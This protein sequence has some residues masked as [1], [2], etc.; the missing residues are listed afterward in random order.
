MFTCFLPLIGTSQQIV[1]PGAVTFIGSEGAA[2][3]EVQGVFALQV[4][5]I[6]QD[7]S[8]NWV[9]VGSGFFVPSERGTN[10]IVLGVTCKHV[11]EAAERLANSPGFE[12]GLLIGMNTQEGY[13]R[14]PCNIVYQDPTNDVAIIAP[15][16]ELNA[17]LNI[18]NLMIP[19]NN[20]DD[21]SSLVLG[22][23]VLIIG[24]PLMLGVEGDQNHPI[25]RF[26][27]IAQ[28]S[29]GNVFLIDGM[30]SHG[31]SGS[32]VFALTPDKQPLIGMITS[33]Q[34]DKITLL[35]ENGG[36]TAQL[37]YN[38]GL[39]GAVKASAILSAI[40]EASKKL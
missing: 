17:V 37:P 8:H 2:S 40:K 39:A 28:N 19:S 32:P 22:R 24:Y 30:A 15:Q 14:F 10:D 13:K 5:Q 33:F 4:A 6:R 38:S 18:N 7:N 25:V 29:G 23:G 11:V 16:T 31:N 12:K 35:D 27:M 36:V 34:S 26:G 1:V 20:F 21:G 9:P 3:I